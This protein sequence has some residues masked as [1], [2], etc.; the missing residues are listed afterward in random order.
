MLVKVHQLARWLAA[1]ERL[2]S[3]A[4]SEHPD[5]EAM[6]KQSILGSRN[7]NIWN[8]R[9]TLKT[10]QIGIYFIG[11]I[12]Q[13][14]NNLTVFFVGLKLRVL[15]AAGS[16]WGIPRQPLYFGS[17][18]FVAASA[19]NHENHSLWMSILIH[20]L[21]TAIL[22]HLRIPINFIK[23]P[24]VL[25]NELCFFSKLFPNFP[26]TNTKPPCIWVLVSFADDSSML[27]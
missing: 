5:P 27:V 15:F 9:N 10:H 13:L 23:C 20:F 4:A 6:K 25:N 3:L 1:L 24:H 19:T 16:D 17:A 18:H 11:C 14:W 26:W 2:G 21:D 7:H 22:I 8:T 12:F